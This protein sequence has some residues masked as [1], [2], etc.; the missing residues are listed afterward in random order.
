VAHSAGSAK[1]LKILAELVLPELGRQ[2]TAKCSGPYQARAWM[3][4][5]KSLDYTHPMKEDVKKKDFSL[6]L[7]EMR[8]W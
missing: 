8:V 6:P 2:R 5:A 1:K 4:V 3:V 7:G